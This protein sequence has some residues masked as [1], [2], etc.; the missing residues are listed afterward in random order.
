[1]KVAWNVF[2]V[3]KS[4]ISMGL[5]L[6]LLISL[7]QCRQSTAVMPLLPASITVEVA[8]NEFA[9]TN[10]KEPSFAEHE[11]STELGRPPSFILAF[12]NLT[13]TIKTPTSKTFPFLLRRIDLASSD[14]NSHPARR[15]LLDSISGEARDGEI[16][17]IIGASGSGKSTLIDALADR[18]SKSSLGKGGVFLNGHPLESN[19]QKT[20]SAYVL[21]DDL[22]FPMLTVEETLTFAAEFR[23]PRWLSASKKRARVQALIDQ[24]G[25]R[26]AA[27]TIIGDEGHRG[28]SGGERRRVSIGTDI[29]HDP[30]LLFLDEPTS[31]LDSTSAFRVMKVLQMI[32]SSGSVVVTSIHQPSARIMG[33]LDRLLILSQGRTIFFGSPNRLADFFADF[34]RP[35]SQGE[36]KA[37]FALDV[38]REQ[39]ERPGGADKLVQFFRLR[40]Q[41]SI[42]GLSEARS[43][44]TLEAAIT[45]SISRG[46]LFAAAILDGMVLISNFFFIA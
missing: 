4:Y 12:H 19:I 29:I 14:G 24:L 41:G 18:I 25:L 26:A 22:L 40:A 43:T 5:L 36:N 6:E 35:M 37:E 39:E 1:M 46:K 9:G 27:S 2:S 33:L 10:F 20:I 23:L 8:D 45:A 11:F 30:I 7:S 34:G 3:L 15:T 21:Q 28:V 44:S 13:Y 32:A 38:V 42:A 16:L 17:A 31:G